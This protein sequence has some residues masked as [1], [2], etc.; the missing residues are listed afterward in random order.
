MEDPVTFFIV[1]QSL[2][3]IFT[4]KELNLR[5]GGRLELLRDYDLQIQYHPRKANVVTNALSRKAQDSPNRVV[6]TQR[7]LLREVEDLGIQL[8]SHG[9]ATVQLSA[10]TLQLTIM[11]ESSEPGE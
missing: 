10:V 7:S 6:I 8:V 4:Q 3:D 9:Q 2:K 11:E 5:Q 1:H